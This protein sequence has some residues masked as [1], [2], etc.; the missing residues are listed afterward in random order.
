MSKYVLVVGDTVNFIDPTNGLPHRGVITKYDPDRDKVNKDSK[1]PLRNYLIKFD[2]SWH[3]FEDAWAASE[4]CELVRKPNSNVKVN[5]TVSSSSVHDDK[6]PINI[7]NNLYT[8]NIKLQKSDVTIGALR[9]VCQMFYLVLT[10]PGF[11]TTLQVMS[12][13]T[14]LGLPLTTPMEI[15]AERRIILKISMQMFPVC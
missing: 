9:E 12:S 3:G 7:N 5:Y 2:K 1:R 6:K 8:D 4:D 14:C 15:R 10:S 13:L 11:P